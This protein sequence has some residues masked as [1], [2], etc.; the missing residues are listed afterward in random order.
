MKK[1]TRNA[2]GPILLLVVSTGSATAFEAASFF[3]TDNS[4]ARQGLREFVDASIGEIERSITTPIRQRGNGRVVKYEYR[5]QDGWHYQLFVNQQD[6]AFPVYSKGSYIIRRD[7][8]GIV[9]QVKVFLRSDPAFFARVYPEQRGISVDVVAAGVLL[10]EAI[11]LPIALN[12]VL[13]ESFEIVMNA[14]S[15]RVD[16]RYLLAKPA[17]HRYAAVSAM[18]SAARGAL[19]TLPDAEDGAMDADGNLVFIESLVLQDQTAGFN[20]SG[21]AK[22]IVDG[23]YKPRTGTYTD[24]DILRAKHLDH[25]GTA[26]ASFYEDERDPYFGLDW[27]RN[28]ARVMISLESG[29]PFDQIDPESADVRETSYARYTEDVGFPVARLP[30]VLYDLAMREPG[31]FYIASL[32]RD[33]G[34]SP[35]LHQHTHIAVVFPY[36]TRDGEYRVSVMER[37]VETGLQSLLNR[38]ERDFVH[39]VRV[40][41]SPQYTPPLVEFQD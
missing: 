40:E 35:S 12:T 19:H 33:F 22:W 9:D 26:L 17:D 36:F 23:L 3:W 11:R 37:N 8:D 27:S 32:N 41:A 13:F 16:W 21:F 31:H 5:V 18:A 7:E 30:I 20:C 10:H 24:I 39:L 29:L 14:S 28:L 15:S 1:I 25:R 38:Y 4:E 34:S 6:G 2:L